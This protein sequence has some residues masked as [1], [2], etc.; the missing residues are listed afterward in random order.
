[1]IG[2][3]LEDAKGWK[4][5]ESVLFFLFIYQSGS[6]YKLNKYGQ[7]HLCRPLSNPFLWVI[8]KST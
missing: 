7:L 2:L 5:M 3:N 6:E 1:M 4:M 8:F